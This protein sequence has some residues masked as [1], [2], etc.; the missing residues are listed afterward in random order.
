MQNQIR[1]CPKDRHSDQTSQNPKLKIKQEHSHETIDRT[2]ESL[3]RAKQKQK[4]R[5]T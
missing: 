3:A 5:Y 2:D 1:T 4:Q